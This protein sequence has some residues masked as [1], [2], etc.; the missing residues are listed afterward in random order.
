[1][2]FETLKLAQ[3][4]GDRG[5][6]VAALQE[7]GAAVQGSS[8]RCPFHADSR[9]SASIHEDDSGTWRVTCHACG[10]GGDVVDIVQRSRGLDFRAACAVL[11]INGNGHGGGAETQITARPAGKPAPHRG[12]GHDPAKLAAECAA[13]LLAD[14]DALAKLHET[15]AIDRVTAERVG[16]GIDG[17]G[18]YW[19]FSVGGAVKHHRVD[20]HGDGPKCFWVPTGAGSRR[21]WPVAPEG[22]GPVWLCPGELKALAVAVTGRP[23]IG[24]TGGESAELPDELAEVLAGR[25]V[26]IAADDDQAGRR[27]AAKA[28]DTL[29]AG[30]LDVRIVDYGADAA[31][32]LKDIGDVLAAQIIDGKD[33]TERAAFIDAVYER[34]DPWASYKIGVILSNP[35]TWAPVEHVP[36]GWAALDAALGGG[37]RCGG[38]CLI[39]GPSARGKTQLV[40]AL[41]ADVA[42][43]GVPIGFISVEMAVRDIGHLFTA[44]V[45]DVPRPWLQKGSLRGAPAQR[46]QKATTEAAG[47]PLIVLDDSFWRGPLTRSRLA[48]IV[49]E[50]V[51]R[52]GWRLVV[53]DY[54]ALIASEP[55]DRSDYHAEVETSGVL[56]RLASEHDI[57]LVILADLR[58]AATFQKK[59]E[60]AKVVTLDDFRGAARL[61][62]DATTV[63]FLDSEQADNGRGGEPTGLIKLTALKTRYAAAGSRRTE[64][65]LRWHP[66]TGRITDL[67]GVEDEGEDSNDV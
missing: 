17:S 6:L 33:A 63:I 24:I 20:P 52:F 67:E 7:A 58:K 51:R 66:L 13:R 21:L 18:R 26:A 55:D 30:G 37:L 59:T 60:R 9:A 50:G 31:A 36:T 14:A 42:R 39:G 5:R 2:S 25:T 62:Y 38:V 48:G 54:L 8:V 44:N 40:T 19:T 56:K 53:L 29:T 47:W 34:A 64:V 41:A 4:R 35:T 12:G 11:G 45:A 32:G 15:R 3:L 1:M 10:A 57:A 49:G 16:L 65:Q 22:P 61:T 28:R 23:A 46:V 27:W 43:R